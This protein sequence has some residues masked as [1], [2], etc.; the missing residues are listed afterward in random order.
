WTLGS[1]EILN[2]NVSKPLDFTPDKH[3]N[4]VHTYLMVSSPYGQLTLR[5]SHLMV[6]SPYGQLGCHRFV[7]CQVL[8]SKLSGFFSL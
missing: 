7:L 8:S 1:Q 5:S 2:R 4:N 6:S 3:N